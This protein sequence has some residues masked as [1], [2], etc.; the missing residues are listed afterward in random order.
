MPHCTAEHTRRAA[1]VL[2]DLCLGG[3]KLFVELAD[4]TGQAFEHSCRRRVARGEALGDFGIDGA[5]LLFGAAVSVAWAP[6][7]TGLDL[8]EA[9]HVEESAHGEHTAHVKVTRVSDR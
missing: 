4:I 7:T 1:P 3:R 6:E 2:R 5:I 8:D 9:S